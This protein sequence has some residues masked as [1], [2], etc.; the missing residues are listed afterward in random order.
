MAEKKLKILEI[1]DSPENLETVRTVLSRAFPGAVVL[2]ADS[3]EKGLALARAEN[4]DIVLLDIAMPGLDG[5]EV[6]R[7]LKASDTLKNI[8]VIFVTADQIDKESRIKALEVGGDGFLRKPFE[9]EELIVQ[10]RIMTKIKASPA[11]HGQ[12]SERLRTLANTL[13]QVK[14]FSRQVPIC[15]SCKKIRN[16]KGNWE[17]VERYLK[18]HIDMDFTH[19]CCP[20]CAQKLY[21]DFIRENNKSGGGSWSL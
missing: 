15:A 13:S 2:T 7:R 16:S 5:F 1:D 14:P 20:E 12:A 19:G 21:P 6:C 4:P 8:P 18:E 17:E 11:V 9:L 10:V 3:G